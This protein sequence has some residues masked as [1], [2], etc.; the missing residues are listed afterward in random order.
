M[1]DFLT[2]RKMLTPWL[3]QIL[4][5]VAI[6][7]FIVIAITDIIQH[8]STRVVLEI[9]IIG[10]LATRIFCELLILFFRMNDNLTAIKERYGK[11]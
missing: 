11:T 10:P 9:V 6:A 2:F 1:K 4:F 3:V 8:V 5:W 7:G